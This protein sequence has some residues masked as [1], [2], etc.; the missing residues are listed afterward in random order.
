MPAGKTLKVTPVGF[1]HSLTD[2]APES[3][4]FPACM[5]S[6]M[7][8]LGEDDP[9]TTLRAHNRDYTQRTANVDF[10]T[11]SGMAFG[12]LWHREYCMSSLDLTQVQP[13]DETIRHA[14]G[15]AGYQ[16]EILE[17]SEDGGNREEIRRRIVRS[18][19]EGVPVLAF[20][21]IGPPECLI[22]CGYDDDGDTLLGWS[23]FAEAWRAQR[24]PGGMFRKTGWYDDLWKIVLT[25]KKTGRTCSL[26]DVLA[27]GLAI[28]EK[29][30]TD[31]YAA[32]LAAYDEWIGYVRNPGLSDA[33]DDTLKKRHEFHHCLVGNLAEARCWAAV[34]LRRAA[35]ETG[36]DRL[37]GIARCFQDIHDWCWKV[38]GVLGAFG[39]SDVW[40]VFRSAENRAEIARLLGEIRAFDIQAM[41]LLRQAL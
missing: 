6:L 29:T 8:A 31:G 27:R 25:G 14:F 39:D 5:A 17:K 2:R 7:E 24:D 9:I 28:M 40:K 32:G 33:D 10:L 16:Y 37:H 38:W 30:E 26:R 1:F 35:E 15:W 36:D 21:I 11:A 18:I 13:H 34:F 41:E 22:L 19:D 20:G 23:H 12:L 4:P 3:F